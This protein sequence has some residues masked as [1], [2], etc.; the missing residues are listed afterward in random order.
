M[1]FK[2]SYS[3]LIVE[4][5]AILVRCKSDHMGGMNPRIILIVREREGG[6]ALRMSTLEHNY[7]HKLITF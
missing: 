7:S 3:L 4:V 1:C 2:H 5:E 6:E